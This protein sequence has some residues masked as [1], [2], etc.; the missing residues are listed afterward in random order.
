VPVGESVVTTGL[1]RIYPKGLMVGTIE[2]VEDNPNAPWHNL[3]VRP[4]APVDHAEHVL[5]LLVEQKDLKM[6]EKIK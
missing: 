2:R 5:V 1:D 6:E 3:I 4:S